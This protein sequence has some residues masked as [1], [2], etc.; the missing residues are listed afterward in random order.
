[1]AATWKM[2]CAALVLSVVAVCSSSA[3]TAVFMQLSPLALGS[4]AFWLAMLWWAG[5]IAVGVLLLSWFG[6]RWFCGWVCP[7]GAGVM[8]HQGCV[9]RGDGSALIGAE[10][11]GKNIGKKK[12]SAKS[13]KN[14]CRIGSGTFLVVGFSVDGSSIWRQWAG[15]FDPLSQFTRALW[16]LQHPTSWLALCV[17]VGLATIIFIRIRAKT[18]LVSASV[19]AWG[20]VVA[21]CQACLATLTHDH[22]V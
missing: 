11:I 3:A 4:A 22:G 1:M 10:N 17:V 18:F 6:G 15:W 20:V 5:V 21:Q 7:V 16:A 12:T 8:L 9:S 2:Q 19:S 13:C 14:H